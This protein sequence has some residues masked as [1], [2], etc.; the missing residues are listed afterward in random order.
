[1]HDCNSATLLQSGQSVPVLCLAKALRHQAYLLPRHLPCFR[2]LDRL[3]WQALRKLLNDAGEARFKQKAR[4]FQAEVFRPGKSGEAGQ[5]LFRGMTR[6]LGYAKNTKPFEK[7]ADRMPLAVIESSE[8]LIQKQ[9]LLLGTAG[10]LPSQRWPG[11]L[12]GEKD[13]RELEQIWRSAGKELKTMKEDDWNFSHIYPNNSPV[14]RI[15]ALSYLIERY[16]EETLL[17]GILQLVEEAPLPGGHRVLENGLT[18]AGD[19]YWRDYFDLDVASKTKVGALLG[20]S[21]AGEIVVNVA[22][23]FTFSWGKVTGEARLA[24]KAMEL[25]RNY[26]RLAEN[27]ITRHMTK[28]LCLEDLSDFTAC[29]QQGL[30]HIF[31]NYCREGGCCE[32]PL[33]S[34]ARP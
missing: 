24:E 13:V 18:V 5:V 34:Q 1:W 9:A 31:R 4:H 19:G 16:R 8:G 6:A 10:L 27:Y 2:I 30:I 17:A 15:V 22:L 21:K 14:R 3:D 33:S 28:Q 23:P 25:Y 20:N 11:K 26:P 32:C 29:H 12:A 7:L